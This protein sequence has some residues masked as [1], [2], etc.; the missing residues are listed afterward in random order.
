MIRI[1]SIGSG[2]LFYII[3]FFVIVDRF[4]SFILVLY[5]LEEWGG[6]GGMLGF[7]YGVSDLIYLYFYWGVGRVVLLVYYGMVVVIERIS[8]GVKRWWG[9]VCFFLVKGEV[10]L[11]KWF[12]YIRKSW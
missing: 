12:I 5:Y 3:L 2:K 9:D 10:Y 11:V 6:K 7:L 8:G 1:W 4:F